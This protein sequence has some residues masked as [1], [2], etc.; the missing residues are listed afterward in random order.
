[1]YVVGIDELWQR[2]WVHLHV[3]IEEPDVRKVCYAF[4]R[5]H[6]FP[7]ECFHAGDIRAVNLG[8]QL[9]T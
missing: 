8:C 6:D 7:E 2:E 1:M 9:T 3:G 5:E 4:G